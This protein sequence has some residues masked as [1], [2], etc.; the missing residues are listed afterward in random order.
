MV[1]I[2]VERWRQ[3][4]NIYRRVGELKRTVSPYEKILGGGGGGGGK[5]QCFGGLGILY[6]Y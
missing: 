5:I 6:F 2:T 4:E 1:E 3:I